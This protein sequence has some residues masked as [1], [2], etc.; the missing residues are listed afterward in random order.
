MFS[1]FFRQILSFDQ[2]NLFLCF[3]SSFHKKSTR[4]FLLKLI[5]E[6]WGFPESEVVAEMRFDIPKSY[7]FHKSKSKDVEVDLIRIFVGGSSSN[8][9][10]ND[11]DGDDVCD[12][13]DKDDGINETDE[14]GENYSTISTENI[15]GEEAQATDDRNQE[16][17][18]NNTSA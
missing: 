4:S 7:N 6:D 10:N 5:R 2:L 14:I 11:I 8:N 13:G 3:K 16:G 9:N 18:E 12:T 15:H 17:E 1:L